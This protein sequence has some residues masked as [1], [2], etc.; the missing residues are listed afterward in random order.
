[1]GRDIPTVRIIKDQ[2]QELRR[3]YPVLVVLGEQLGKS[4]VNKDAAVIK[5]FPLVPEWNVYSVRDNARQLGDVNRPAQ[6]KHCPS[7]VL[8]I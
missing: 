8:S 7:N 5:R 1:M 6:S 2:G 3:D 4:L